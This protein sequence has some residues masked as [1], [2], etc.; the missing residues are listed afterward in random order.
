MK[1]SIR[2]SIVFLS[3]VLVSG[4]PLHAGGKGGGKNT[5]TWIADLVAHDAAFVPQDPLLLSRCSGKSTSK[6]YVEW[7]RHDVCVHTAVFSSGVW[8]EHQGIKLSGIEPDFTKELC[9]PDE[10]CDDPVLSTTLRKGSITSLQFFVQDDTGPDGIM[11]ETDVVT[12]NPPAA[13]SPCGFLVHVHR[14]GIPVWKL[15][16]HLGGPRVAF[17]GNTSIADV[18]YRTDPPCSN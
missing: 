14:N 18:W 5:S 6:F 16:G 7:P 12:L 2:F 4:L 17:V 3:L 8:T 11:H 10:L 13:T 1:S 9:N 15:S